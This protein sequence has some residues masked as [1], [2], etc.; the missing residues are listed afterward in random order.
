MQ[1]EKQVIANYNFKSG[2]YL[3]NINEFKVL[4]KNKMY[5]NISKWQ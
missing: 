4:L 3:E 2:N 5:K 1:Y